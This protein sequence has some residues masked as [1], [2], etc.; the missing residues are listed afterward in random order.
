MSKPGRL[1][2]LQGMA[3][4]VDTG[5]GAI[6]RPGHEIN[7]RSGRFSSLRWRIR[8][9]PSRTRSAAPASNADASVPTEEG[10]YRMHEEFGH[11]ASNGG[12]PGPRFSSAESPAVKPAKPVKAKSRLGLLIGAGVVGVVALLAVIKFGQF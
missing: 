6:T 2:R 10:R 5:V 4:S 1:D 7:V 3:A 8:D 11:I 9:A 12:A